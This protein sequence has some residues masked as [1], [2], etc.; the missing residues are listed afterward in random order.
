MLKNYLTSAWR[1]IIHNS[2]YSFINIL[3]LVTGMITFILLIQFVLHEY[4]YDN[5]LDKSNRLF[6]VEQDRYDKGELSTR[7]ASGCAGIGPALKANFPEVESYV[8]LRKNGAVFSIEDRSYREEDIFFA[9][10][11]FFNMFSIPLIRGVD[12]LVLKEPFCMVISQSMARKY[13]NN[14]DPLGKTLRINGDREVKI[15]GVF[16]DL[17]ENTHMKFD[18]LISFATFETFFK[19]LNDLNTW[20]WDAYMTYIL[21][22]KNTDPGAFEAKLPA[23]VIK[24]HGEELRHAN[25][26]IIF[27]L[28]PVRSIHLD[29]NF[30]FE[31]QP[32][33]NRNTTRYL[34][35]IA[36]IILIIA[37]INYVNLSTARSIELSPVHKWQCPRRS[38]G[39]PGLPF[40]APRRSLT[41]LCAVRNVLCALCPHKERHLRTPAPQSKRRGREGRH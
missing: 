24:E 37:W 5:F 32:N 39:L 26:N 30:M 9:G 33:G 16:K 21:L 13:F 23:F 12:S 41:P 34:M 29:S 35:V 20:N 22:N 8:R 1:Y 36:I 40:A 38:I 10:N 6:R 18:G 11:S 2:F 19:D 28:Q 25:H 7:W 17:P 31:F 3:G 14:E 15:T 27:H 4:S